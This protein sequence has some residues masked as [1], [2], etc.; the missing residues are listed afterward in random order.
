M[1]AIGED[2]EMNIRL[3]KAEFSGSFDLVIRE[4]TVLGRKGYLALLDGM[5]DE[6]RLTEA[7][8][9][10]LPEKAPQECGTDIATEVM[11]RYYKG[12]DVK[13]LKSTEDAVNALPDG[14]AVLFISSCPSALCFSLQGY[15]RRAVGEPQTEQNEYGAREAFTDSFKDNAV[16]LRRRLRIPE[17]V[18]EQMTLGSG[19]RTPVL[20]CYVKG[21]AEMGTVAAVREKLAGA[22]PDISLGTGP[23]RA[24]LGEGKPT[25]FPV[26]G[27]TERPDTLAAM[28]AEGRIGVIADG[29]PFAVIVPGLLAD[30]F[31]AADD[32]F[33]SPVYALFMRVLRIVCFFT[34]A[35]LPGLFVA[36]C[37]FHPE[38]LPSD[39]MYE[40]A[41]AESKTPF[42][43]MTE[44]LIIHFIYEIV[45][46]A[47]LRMPSAA[48][49]AVSI[50][51][52]LVIGDAAV[53][54]GLIA[55]PMLIIVALT[56]ICSSVVSKLHEPTAILRFVFI[57]AGGLTGIFGIMLVCAVTVTVLCAKESC[58]V[59]YT[60]PFSPFS[61]KAQRDGI[62][63]K[64]W[65]KLGEKPTR[66]GEMRY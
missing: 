26:T 23:V 16:L 48:G 18:I 43:L 64:N 28:L 66:I 61:A 27:T 30:S 38:V 7:L 60:A 31:H 21:R 42:P 51:G 22:R 53:T 65:K 33:S 62:L 20:L 10:P 3:L 52:A 44:A 40:I 25:I 19:S 37:L 36:A 5:C 47:G 12:S 1:A 32:Y 56:A 17:L 15:A 34:A 50:V 49:H 58:G 4:L 54:A 45:R 2:A 39:I 11:K 59:P 8:V 46:E 55:A 29:T 63:R 9:K 41:A 24:F 57:V 13:L 6:M 14:N 35:G